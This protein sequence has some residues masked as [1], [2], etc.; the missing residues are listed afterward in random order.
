MQSEVKRAPIRTYDQRKTTKSIAEQ[1]RE[2]MKMPNKFT[3]EQ[4]RPYVTTWI[5]NE[6]DEQIYS[7][8]NREFTVRQ[9]KYR[10]RFGYFFL[11]KKQ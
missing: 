7:K 3:G 4:A 5:D 6:E 1:R 2:A 9:E 11:K 10:Q 8:F